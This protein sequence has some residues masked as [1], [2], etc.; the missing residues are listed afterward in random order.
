METYKTFHSQYPVTH[1]AKTHVCGDF[2]EQSMISLSGYV[3]LVE[4]VSPPVKRSTVYTL[5]CHGWAHFV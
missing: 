4:H 5:G 2:D 3:V 1:L